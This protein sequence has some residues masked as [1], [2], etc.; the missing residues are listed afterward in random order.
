MTLRDQLEALEDQV[1]APYAMRSRDTR[2][3]QHPEPEH[4]SR[5]VYQRDRERILHTAAFR[6]L[7]DKTQVFVATEGDHYRTRL[8][9]TLE[10]AQ[11]GRAVARMLRVNEDLTEAVCL[12]HDLGHPPFGHPGE[13]VLD[14]L[15]RGH[16]GF[17]HGDQSLRVVDWLEQRYPDF[18][19]LNLS[20]ETRE[21]MVKHETDYDLADAKQFEPGRRATIEAQIVNHADE[22]AYLAADLDDGLHA[23][24]LT[25]DMLKGVALWHELL[26]GQHPGETISDLDRH[27][28]VRRFI[29]RLV[30]DLVEA[31]R[32]RLEAGSIETVR[33]VRDATGNVVGP[34]DKTRTHLKQLSGFLYDHFYFDRR[35]RRMAA[36]AGRVLRDI[37][38]AY[39]DEPKQ[40]PPDVLG[41]AEDH[42]LERTI[43]DYLAGMTDRFA[44]E[45]HGRLFDPAIRV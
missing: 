18:R 37:F 6:R 25:P 34:S 31:T 8:T 21:G 38:E 17:N 39:L 36:K 45:E 2:G 7:R 3:R 22:I 1:L 9:H 29:D 4:D 13:Y 43:C 16:G 12:A 28:L 23:G 41:Q 27:V 15:M 30:R 5:T 10:V 44:L 19:G 40:M 14:E 11:I 33:A 42:G 24:I 26:D 20:W 35:V 32:G